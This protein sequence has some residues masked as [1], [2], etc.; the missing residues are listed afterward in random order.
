MG[1]I[2]LWAYAY[3]CGPLNLRQLGV[4]YRRFCFTTTDCKEV[5]SVKCFLEEMRL[6]GRVVPWPKLPWN[7]ATQAVLKPASASRVRR[8]SQPRRCRDFNPVLP[9]CAR[10]CWSHSW[11]W[12]ICRENLLEP[13]VDCCWFWLQLLW[14]RPSFS[15][16]ADGHLFSLRGF[17]GPAGTKQGKDLIVI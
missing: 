11:T 3:I 6:W 4:G 8:L 12:L 15:K 1:N 16:E 14:P 10:A 9:H 2:K 17:C 7:Y 13:R 5:F